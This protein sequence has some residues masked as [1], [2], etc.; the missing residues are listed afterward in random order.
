[1]KSILVWV[2]NNKENLCKKHIENLLECIQITEIFT[3]IAE[4]TI[5]WEKF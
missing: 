4:R 5:K 3:K 2:Q 1:M